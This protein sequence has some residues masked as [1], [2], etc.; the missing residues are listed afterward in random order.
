MRALATFISIGML[1][2]STSIV[3]AQH[4]SRE[5]TLKELSI[6][7]AKI[8]EK[9]NQRSTTQPASFQS[10]IEDAIKQAS[11]VR[12]YFANNQYIK[13]TG[14]SVSVPP[15]ISVNVDFK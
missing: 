15:S 11:A 14:F 6:Q 1:M 2:S 10:A 9:L 13:I 12:D 7:L 3:Y 5:E 4:M 8:Q